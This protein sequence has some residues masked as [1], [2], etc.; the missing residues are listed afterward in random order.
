MLLF[1]YLY[2]FKAFFFAG[3]KYK[4]KTNHEDNKDSKIA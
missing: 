3:I 4:P 1:N 2:N